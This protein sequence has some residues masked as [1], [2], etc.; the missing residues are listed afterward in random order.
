MP[1]KNYCAVLADSTAPLIVAIV[2]QVDPSH[3]DNRSLS[4]LNDM[5]IMACVTAENVVRARLKD[6]GLVSFESCASGKFDIVLATDDRDY[7]VSGYAAVLSPSA[8]STHR[9]FFVRI[10]HNPN[11]Y[12]DWG[13]EVIKVE[14]DP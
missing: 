6:Q 9:R 4:Y 13:F 1:I 5:R 3:A 7:K 12:S 2:L 14:I 8:G 10:N 11:S